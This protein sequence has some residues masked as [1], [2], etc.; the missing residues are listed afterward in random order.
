MGYINNPAMLA[1]KERGA[2]LSSQNYA[3][4]M[5]GYAEL[6]EQYKEIDEADFPDYMDRF[7]GMVGAPTDFIGG[8]P[9]MDSGDGSYGP[10]GATQLADFGEGAYELFDKFTPGM[11]YM[12]ENQGVGEQELANRLGV[13]SAEM[14]KNIAGQEGQATRAMGRMGIDPSSGAWQAGAGERSIDA[15]AGLSGLQQNVRTD[16]RDEDWKQRMET[17]G[18]GLNLAGQGTDALST[19]TGAYTDALGAYGGMYGDYIGGLSNMGN[20]T[21][22]ARQYNYSQAGNLA[23]GMTGALPAFQDTSLGQYAK[24]N[25][26]F[27]GGGI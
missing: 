10:I 20:L 18:I 2:H 14:Q 3:R 19:A 9:G 1:L 7:S 22:N 5:P 21:E 8:L 26:G 4:E 6:G 24:Y 16:A 17:A 13:S 27:L 15:A 23:Q 12:A 25:T 11:E